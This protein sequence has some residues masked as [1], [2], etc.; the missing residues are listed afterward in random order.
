MQREKLDKSYM[1][2]LNKEDLFDDKFID[3]KLSDYFPD[4]IG[5][6]TDSNQAKQFIKSLFLA[7][8]QQEKIF[9]R[10]TTAIDENNIKSVFNDIMHNEFFT[11]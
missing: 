11:N 5:S 10:F 4:Y 1:L 9:T 7:G 3:I 8:I 2:M 6:E